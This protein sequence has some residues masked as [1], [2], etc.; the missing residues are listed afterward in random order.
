MLLITLLI[1]D[2]PTAI[3]GR[4][5]LFLL[6]LFMLFL[7]PFVPRKQKESILKTADSYFLLF[8]SILKYFSTLS[9]NDDKCNHGNVLPL[10]VFFHI[11]HQRRRILLY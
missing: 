11:T 8:F 4:R 1:R 9:L 3:H 10:Y 2:A 7:T 5:F 6:I